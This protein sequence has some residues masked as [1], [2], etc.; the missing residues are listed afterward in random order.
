[1][2]TKKK[3]Y[4]PSN[5]PFSFAQQILKSVLDGCQG[6]PSPPHF[7][8]STREGWEG[9]EEARITHRPHGSHKH[10]TFHKGHPLCRALGSTPQR[11]TLW[12][13][14]VLSVLEP[15]THPLHTSPL[16][17]LGSASSASDS[18]SHIQVSTYSSLTRF[19]SQHFSSL[20]HSLGCSC[21]STLP[22]NPALGP[23]GPCRCLSSH[24]PP[25]APSLTGETKT[26]VKWAQLAP[27]STLPGLLSRILS[28]ALTHKGQ[29]SQGAVILMWAQACLHLAVH[30]SIIFMS[31]APILLPHL[32]NPEFRVLQI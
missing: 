1:M 32:S 21:H 8:K 27:N 22:A 9:R 4:L 3:T 6:A 20:R 7:S 31:S 23:P 12:T 10:S 24:I 2:M 25:P 18:A 26:I 17:S 16:L 13:S 11:G 5:F 19:L 15:L 30:N 14:Q 29:T 28:L